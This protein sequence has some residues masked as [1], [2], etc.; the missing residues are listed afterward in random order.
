MP[1][2]VT[3]TR[4][5]FIHRWIYVGELPNIS[6]NRDGQTGFCTWLCDIHSPRWSLAIA[7]CNY[8][9]YNVN[10]RKEAQSDD[11]KFVQSVEWHSEAVWFDS[12]SLVSSFF[13][14]KR[15]SSCDATPSVSTAPPPQ[16]LHLHLL[17]QDYAVHVRQ[18]K[19]HNHPPHT[20]SWF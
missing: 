18:Y 1:S 11:W 7:L 13:I 19:N 17:F 10:C 14:R 8:L 3:G 12:Y 5:I 16:S 2:K 15:S 9:V 6:I 20:H 4:S